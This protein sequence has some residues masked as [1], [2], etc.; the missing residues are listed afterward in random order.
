[1]IGELQVQPTGNVLSLHG[2]LDLVTV[3][4]L[5]QLLREACTDAP[6]RVVVDLSDVPFVDVLSLS[7]VLATADALREH[8]ASLVVT[9]ASTAVRRICA[10]LNADDVLAPTLPLPRLAVS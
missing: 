7:A 8:G 10:L 5:R 2:D 9:G 1:M 3:E 6:P 4:P